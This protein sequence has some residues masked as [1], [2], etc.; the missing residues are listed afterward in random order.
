VRTARA[1]LRAIRRALDRERPDVVVA[2]GGRILWLVAAALRRRTVPWVAVVHGSE[3][4][5]PA[6]QRRLT[7]RA[8]GRADAI[9]AVSDFTARLLSDAL[10]GRPH[11]V[12]V[13]H[14]G[15][16]DDRFAPD[17]D[18][19]RSFRARH[20]L[21]D[22]PLVVTVGNVTTRKGQHL[23]VEAL[24]HLLSRVPDARY[25][26]VGRPTEAGALRDRA[27]GLGV[28]DHLH[29]VGMVG[30]DEVVDAQRAADVFAMTS[31][32]T[33]DGDVEGFGIAVVEAA[34]CGVPAVVTRGTGAQEAVV[35]GRSGIVVDPT[36]ASIGDALADLLS[37]PPRRARMGEEA[38]AA[39]LRSGT[40][41]H[42]AVQYGEVLDDVASGG[43]PKVV[44]VSHTEH[45][46]GPD[47]TV[48][49]LGSTTR[50]LD[51]LATLASELVH[52]A[53][54]HAG[55]P[56]ASALAPTASNLR[57]V[58]VE[59]A[60]GDSWR[61]R[62]GALATLPRWIA[63]VDREVRSADVVH[64]RCPAGISMA[65]LL[66]LLVR[67]H[68]RD[69]WVKY[70]GEWSPAVAVPATFALQRW[71]LRHGLAR[72]QVT[73]NG[74]FPDQ[75]ASVRTFDNPTLTE[76]ELAEGRKAAAAKPDGPPYR[77]VFAGRLEPDKGADVAVDTTV[78][79][80]GKGIPVVLD[81]VGDGSLRSWA[82]ERAAAAPPGTV[83]VHG[84]CS[85]ARLE[86]LL[87]EAHVL[88]LPSRSEGFPKVVA[89]AM[90][91]GCVPLTSDVGDLRA[92]LAET[93]G[94]EVVPDGGSWPDALTGLLEGD[95]SEHRRRGVEAA[96][97]FSYATYLTQVRRMARDAWGRS[98]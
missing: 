86:A 90:A 70:A 84:W 14:N 68:P 24:P 63:T 11:P 71:W 59:A 73:V 91:F 12:H 4:G 83:T 19:A 89:E 7:R 30:A 93:G 55:P 53:P 6:W 51:Q 64:V 43:R 17:G 37:D 77:L 40:W 38:R 45:W 3:L 58:P 88:V 9:V 81:L 35:D 25:V 34:L 21:G 95:L 78:E 98:L 52:V 32:A 92:T 36:A 44:V 61:A 26:V 1:R 8:L 60:G 46:R 72:A 33:A 76:R 42:R 27:R 96:P 85:R 62:L 47:G 41:T 79:L 16:D 75:P 97:R 94:G 82:E 49:G 18:R 54:L 87:S 69:R 23:V 28:D 22:R 31:T 2:S 67:R 48:V 5:G 56:P 39:A 13:I 20:G 80:A 10:G 57:F 50:E 66:V 15:A 74:R 65:A 29:V